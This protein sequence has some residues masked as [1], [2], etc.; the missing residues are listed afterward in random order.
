MPHVYNYYTNA[1]F[2]GNAR[3]VPI[4]FQIFKKMLRVY[5][6]LQHPWQLHMQVTT[7]DMVEI[8]SIVRVCSIYKEK[9][10][11]RSEHLS[12]LTVQFLAKM[13]S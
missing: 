2:L 1:K 7:E 10:A 3:R 4:A 9:D 6:K 12:V 5:E 11:R 13:N 8:R